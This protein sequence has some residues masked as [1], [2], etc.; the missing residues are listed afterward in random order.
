MKHIEITLFFLAY[1]LRSYNRSYKGRSLRTW[2]N[3]PTTIE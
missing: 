2:Y 1:E 3:N